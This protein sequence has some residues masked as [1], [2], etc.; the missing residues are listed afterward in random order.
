MIRLTLLLLLTV[1]F[2][3]ADEMGNDD[4]R[5]EHRIRQVFRSQP[6]VGKYH[7]G[8]TVDDGVAMLFGNVPSKKVQDELIRLVEA[9]PGVKRVAHQLRI[10]PPVDDVPDRIA[11]AVLL[12]KPITGGEMRL[13]P[14]DKSALVRDNRQTPAMTMSSPARTVLKPNV[15]RVFELDTELRKITQTDLRYRKVTWLIQDGVVRLRGKVEYMQD[16]WDL[17][18]R[19]SG[20]PGVTRVLLDGIGTK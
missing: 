18:D 6:E 15:E 4:W 5:I 13:A 17:A 16:A 3:R 14:D 1:A 10:V 12:G 20:L 11:E 9:V 7:P 19:L 8:V 2:V